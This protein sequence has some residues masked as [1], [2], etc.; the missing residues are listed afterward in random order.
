METSVHCEIKE[1]GGR[2]QYLQPAL[3]QTQQQ[4]GVESTEFNVSATN[5]IGSSVECVVPSLSCRGFL[6][7]SFSCFFFLFPAHFL[8]VWG[9]EKIT[10]LLTCNVLQDTSRYLMLSDNWWV[11]YI[12]PF[13]WLSSKRMNTLSTTTLICLVSLTSCFSPSDWW[14]VF[15]CKTSISA[16]GKSILVRFI[17]ST[18][19][20]SRL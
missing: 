16:S 10:F 3:D 7:L 12:V 6:P 15:F 4:P 1:E 14:W 13:A 11:T 20:V 2:K 5:S 9:E 17:I 19:C 18:F 8:S